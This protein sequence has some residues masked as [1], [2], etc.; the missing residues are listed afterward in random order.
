MAQKRTARGRA[1]QARG[2][3]AATP[4]VAETG[5]AAGPVDDPTMY[6]VD[7]EHV[8][9]VV[10]YLSQTRPD[11]A[12]PGRVVEEVLRCIKCYADAKH[13]EM[14]SM[15]AVLDEAWHAFILNTRDYRAYCE[16]HFG[17][18]IEHSTATSRDTEAEKEVRRGNLRGAYAGTHGRAPPED[19]WGGTARREAQCRSDAAE[20]PEGKRRRTDAG[21]QDGAMTVVVCMGLILNGLRPIN[22]FVPVPKKWT[23]PVRVTAKTTVDELK[24]LICGECGI[25]RTFNRANVRLSSDCVRLDERLRLEEYAIEDND[26]IDVS[27]PLIGC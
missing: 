7:Q 5:G 18:V 10:A 8:R 17:R 12:A 1:T 16:K 24:E 9:E 23:F 4:A 27:H 21:E 2:G 20:L 25:S 22:E 15:P 13:P 6:D 11:V 3:L 19:V 14:Y 26:V